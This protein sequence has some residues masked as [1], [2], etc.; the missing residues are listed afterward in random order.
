MI[1]VF[2]CVHARDRHPDGVHILPCAWR[3]CSGGIEDPLVIDMLTYQRE[4]TYRYDG[5]CA[6]GATY[7]CEYHWVPKE[8]E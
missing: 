1:L 4:F 3:G 6:D 7:H 5:E 8:V 2:P